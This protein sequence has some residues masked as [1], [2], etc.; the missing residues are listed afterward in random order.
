MQ[1]NELTV[2]QLPCGVCRARRD[3]QLTLLEA[4]DSFYQLYGYTREEAE[5]AGF[6]SIEFISYA[7]DWDEARGHIEDELTRGS[8]EFELEFRCAHCAD[9]L[10][11]VLARLRVMDDGSL[12]AVMVDITERRC[13]MEQLQL[14][15]EESRLALEHTGR[16]FFR[17]NLD[18]GCCTLSENTAWELGLPAL[19]EDVP[20]SMIERGHVDGES[21]EEYRNFF[22]GIKRGEP[23]GDM[24]VRLRNHTGDFTWYH[25]MFSQVC[26]EEG[27]PRH[28]VVSFEDFSQQREREIAYEKW[29]QYNRRQM[30]EAMV[31]YE[32]N[33]THNLFEAVEGGE[34]GLIP[35]D[36]RGSY[37][38]TIQYAAD[39]LVDQEDR[40]K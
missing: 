10:L 33:L 24:L 18:T 23:R 30:A 8:G 15:K 32:S 4:N 38:A 29:S 27:V 35:Q 1:G 6:C 40:K 37:E 22:N 13:R 17:Y 20:E 2:G 21:V 3:E 26:D 25:C 31:Y 16:F 5:R 28:A 36:V 19:V 14:T 7:P 34:A 11:W 39:N 12:L 9:H